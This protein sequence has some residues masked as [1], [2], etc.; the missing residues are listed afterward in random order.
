MKHRHRLAC[1]GVL[2]ACTAQSAFAQEDA[3]VVTATRFPQQ[4]LDAPA[5]LVVID[6]KQIRESAAATIPEVL[7]RLG[8]LHGRNLT[9]SPDLQLDLRGFGITGDQNTLVLVDGVRANSNDLSTTSLSAIPLHAIERIE[10]MPGSGAVLYGA[11]TT[12]GTI[13]IITR[14]PRRGERSGY[15]FGGA[16]SYGTTDLRGSASVAGERLGL[17]LHAGRQE[18]DNYRANN[19]LRQDSV[20]GD[21]R[22]ADA[23]TVLG[24]KFGSEW[25]RLRLPG[26][27]NERQLET[28]PR[29]T[30]KPHD[31]NDRSSDRA[32]L[33]A[34]R[35]FQGGEVAADFAFRDQFAE[36]RNTTAFGGFLFADIKY[37][38]YAISPRARFDV[39]PLGRRSS[40]IVG[41]DFADSDY[42]RQTWVT[43]SPAGAP[44]GTN[45]TT[46]SSRGAYVQFNTQATEALKLGAGWRSER[47]D[48]GNQIT[49]FGPLSSGTQKRNVGAGEITARY[50]VSSALALFG[51]AGTSFRFATADDNAQTATGRLLAPQTARHLEGGAELRVGRAK[52]RAAAY[53]VDI[54]NEIYFSPIVIPFGANTNLSPTYREGI[55][56]DGTWSGGTAYEIGAR[57]AYQVAKFKEGVY[58]GVNVSGKDVPLVP[59][60]LATLRGSW[61]AAPATT[62][63]GAVTHVGHQR[64]DNDQ[65]NAFAHLMPAYTLFDV[66]LAH[67]R[68]DW[69][70]SASVAN[71]TD[72]KYYSY[73]I[74][75]TFACATP[76]CAYPQVGRALFLSAEKRL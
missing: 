32:T 5:G 35:E 51:K 24:L 23:G 21:L 29:G 2:A 43:Y 6:Q 50:S 66:K 73:G 70:W 68:W 19:E 56:L 17:T 25:Q 3:V 28:D 54:E 69:R 18:S 34:R 61:L 16:G 4:L 59:R 76:L 33:Y 42:R 27:R 1:A 74:V 58:G 22:Y 63:S 10:I 31:F 39:E 62:L 9:G 71:L 65:A 30:S 12:G 44:A 60:V 47:V 45:S 75:N 36:T 14:G 67:E 52:A 26:E 8:G 46:Q 64:Y 15:L 38:T 13:N 57:V 11:G 48:D 49:F 41:A 20:L 37:R 40:L 53:R 55:E 72:K 7:I